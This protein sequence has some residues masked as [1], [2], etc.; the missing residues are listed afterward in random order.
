MQLRHESTEQLG[1]LLISAARHQ[2]AFAKA[3]ASYPELRLVALADERDPIPWV[4]EANKQ[5]AQEW[6]LPYTEDLDGVLA[7]DEIDIV[8]VCSEYSRHGTLAIKA[9]EAG[10]HVILDKQPTGM[11]FDEA[12]RVFA[13][14]KKAERSGVK[15]SYI[16]H[17]V[18]PTV[19]RAQEVI[20]HGQIGE[21]RAVYASAIVTYGPGDDEDTSPTGYWGKA[22]HRDWWDGGELIHH[23]GYAIGCARYVM[24]SEITSVF[25]IVGSHFNRIHQECDI[26]D[27]TTLSLGFANG[28]V[29]TLVIGRVPNRAHP[30]WADEFLHVVGTKGIVTADWE[31]PSY[32]MCS[33]EDGLSRRRMYGRAETTQLAIDDFV[34][35]VLHD[36]QPLRSAS[37]GLVDTKVILAGYQ[38]AQEGRV[39]SL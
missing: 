23:G 33:E 17:A 37:D 35:S 1:V 18:D 36:K 20:E 31:G 15:L 25:A 12:E 24:G 29:G 10:K 38:S 19:I 32:L 6:N 21:P 28:G 11:T 2:N 14:A 34:Q 22:L 5:L 9:L 26:D 13:A 16:H 8:T 27:L 4:R 7:S 30:G 39:V 3:L